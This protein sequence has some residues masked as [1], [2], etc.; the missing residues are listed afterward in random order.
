MKQKLVSIVI[1]IYNVEK[2]LDRCIRS[3]V[4]QSYRELEIILV[5]DGSTDRCPQICDEWAASDS[6]IKVI[7]KKNAGLGMARN[8][9]IEEA[10]GKY[11]CFF[12]SD[13]YIALDAIEKI[14]RCAVQKE[15][16]IVLFGFTYVDT[17][18]KTGKCHI[19][20]VEKDFY[21]GKEVKSFILPELLAPNPLT[22]KKTNLWM[23]AWLCMYSM[24]LIQKT[25]WR[26]VSER[27]Y[28]SEDVYSLLL[29]Y[30]KI[31]RVSVLPE[32][33]YYYCRNEK[34][35]TNTFR[36]DR[37]DK[38]LF[39][40]RE[41]QTVCEQL[42]YGKIVEERLTLQYLSNVIG[43]LKTIVAADCQKQLKMRYIKNI[44]CDE[45]FQKSVHCIELKKESLPRKVLFL[46]MRQRWYRVVYRLIKAKG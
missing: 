42:Q 19:P 5:D 11:I 36:K 32:A 20:N 24:P 6:R 4:N 16:D 37:Y 41:C 1:S 35:I 22:G 27:E 8:T 38:I 34:S 30:N 28:I 46:T 14:Y 31:E 12:D 3:V 40:Y 10:N 18:G 2:Y 39:C 23:S 9:G 43:A 33:L 7:H 26:F 44:L 29:L 21:C 15:A 45:T 13:D 25:G 17:Y